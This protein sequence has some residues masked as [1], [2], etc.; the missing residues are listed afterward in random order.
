MLHFP[1]GNARAGPSDP[2]RR[3]LAALTLGHHPELARS[4]A[5][6]RTELRAEIA[7]LRTE[8]KVGIA[9]LRAELKGD[10]A[11]LRAEFKKDVG[12]PL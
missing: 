11:G 2:S 10:I 9:G 1:V 12:A 5:D 4:I 3:T 8:L 7:T 6:L